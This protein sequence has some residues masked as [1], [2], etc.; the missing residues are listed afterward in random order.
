MSGWAVCVEGR[1]CRRWWNG[2]TWAGG[3]VGMEEY[4]REMRRPEAR[5]IVRTKLKEGMGSAI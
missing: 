5:K 2:K 4:I 1:G 3:E